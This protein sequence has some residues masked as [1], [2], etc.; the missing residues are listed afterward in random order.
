M[1]NNKKRVKSL[2]IF[3][4]ITSDV[5]GRELNLSVLFGNIFQALASIFL[6]QIDHQDLFFLA[7]MKLPQAKILQITLFRIC[8]SLHRKKVGRI[9]AQ[10]ASLSCG[11]YY[12]FEKI[13]LTSSL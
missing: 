11:T 10:F 6:L 7:R 13:R 1:L 4:F 5:F 9:E 8:I 3:Y 2:F 12:L